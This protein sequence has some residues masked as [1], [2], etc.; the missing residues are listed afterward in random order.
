MPIPPPHSP[1]Q[2]RVRIP[3][4]RDTRHKVIHTREGRAAARRTKDPQGGERY[5][6]LKNGH[7]PVEG[8]PPTSPPGGTSPGGH[9]LPPLRNTPGLHPRA[10]TQQPRTRPHTPPRQRWPR[11][12]RQPPHHLPTLQPITRQPHS[13]TDSEANINDPHRMVIGGMPPPH[14]VGA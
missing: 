2:R 14:P 9:K 6:H 3:T 7:L 4:R 10:T 1:T 13:H 12:A 11:R 8:P 5:G